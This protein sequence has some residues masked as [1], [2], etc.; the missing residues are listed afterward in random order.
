MFETQGSSITKN[1]KFGESLVKSYLQKSKLSE[2]FHFITKGADFKGAYKGKSFCVEVK[3]ASGEGGQNRPAIND[4]VRRATKE[5]C[6]DFFLI[7]LL[8]GTRKA[9]T[10]DSEMTQKTSEEFKKYGWPKEY[11]D[12]VLETMRYSEDHMQKSPNLFKNP[13][14]KFFLINIGFDSLDNDFVDKLNEFAD[15]IEKN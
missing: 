15:F 8:G 6:C 9:K 3:S 2:N 11:E 13:N 7:I 14:Q 1:G 12:E 4:A 10:N 5:Y